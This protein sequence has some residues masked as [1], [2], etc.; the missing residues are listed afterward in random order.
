MSSPKARRRQRSTRLVTATALV[1]LAAIVVLVERRTMHPLY[2]KYVKK[3]KKYAA[4]D[5][6][7]VFRAGD[8]VRI[9]ECSPI[10]KSKRWTVITDAPQ[11]REARQFAA[12]K[13]APSKAPKAKSAAEKP[14]AAPKAAA[15]E[16]A[17]KKPAAKKAAAKKTEA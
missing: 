12:N 14:A 10:S 13:A 5:E 7:N 16:A 15:K 1:V 3:S 2:K 9:Q 11:G 8:V 6:S 4:H 17:P